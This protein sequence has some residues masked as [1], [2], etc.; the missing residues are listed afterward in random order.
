MLLTEPD[1]GG[2]SGA[3]AAAGYG[4]DGE[5]GWAESRRGD[6]ESLSFTGAPAP[7][8]HSRRGVSGESAS[9][10]DLFNALLSTADGLALGEPVRAPPAVLRALR[11]G[12]VFIVHPRP[13]VE[14]GHEG[15]LAAADPAT[16]TAG[17]R[18]LRLRF[19]KNVLPEVGVTLCAGCNRFFAQD[20]FEF[21]VLKRGHCP[22]CRTPG[23][24]TG[25]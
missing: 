9:G 13:M 12:D 10:D 20:D 5:A 25:I 3:A 4:D 17:D 16:V 24:L 15:A 7:S 21:E 23:E 1:G 6:G 18:A 19:F 2:S 11:P 8:S 14:A 22:L